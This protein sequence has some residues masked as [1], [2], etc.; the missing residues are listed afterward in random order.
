MEY[1]IVDLEMNPLGKEFRDEREICKNEVIEFGAVALDENFNE[2]DNFMCL[3]KPQFNNKVERK[4]E[5]LTGITT[6]MVSG[7]VRFEEALKEFAEWCSKSSQ[8]AQIIQWSESD[9]EQIRK[10]M[11]LKGI[12]SSPDQNDTF[13]TWYDF[14]KEVGEML[15][16]ERKVSLHDALMYAGVDFKGKEH[17]ALYDARNTAALLEIVRTQELREQALENVVNILKSEKMN[18]ALGDL[19]DFSQLSL[20]A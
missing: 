18:T 17:D 4:I 8:N 16:L 6:E 15:G 12:T 13:H 3:V 5:K 20:P 2:I 1:I 19:F 11:L 7:G 9:Y 10:E 14:Q